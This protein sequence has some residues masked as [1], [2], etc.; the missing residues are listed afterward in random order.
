MVFSSIPDPVRMS[1]VNSVLRNINTLIP[2]FGLPTSENIVFMT[3][4]DL[5]HNAESSAISKFFI[6]TSEL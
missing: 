2:G 3:T 4:F 6:R 1:D 5:K